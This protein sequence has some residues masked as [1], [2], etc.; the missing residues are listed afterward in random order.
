[1]VARLFANLRNGDFQRIYG[2]APASDQASSYACATA[3]YDHDGYLDLFVANGGSVSDQVNFLYRNSGGTNRWLQ[4]RLIGTAANRAA[5]GAKVRVK[6]TIWS[7]AVWQL[8]QVSGGEGYSQDSL[9]VHFGLG[10]AEIIDTIRIEWPGPAFTVQELHDVPVNQILTIT[11]P[12]PGPVLLSPTL[13]A[14]N[15]LQFTLRGE[16]G[17]T[18]RL[19]SSPDLENWTEED[20]VILED[21]AE[22]PFEVEIVGTVSA[23]YYRVVREDD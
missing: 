10:D 14:S 9:L 15:R 16:Q 13:T 22:Q 21:S 2:A 3:D 1:V 6:A 7:R 19:E 11:E 18:C 23:Q 12:L 8:R 20:V 5:I 4:L 17:Q